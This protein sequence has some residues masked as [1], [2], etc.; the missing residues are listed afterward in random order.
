MRVTSLAFSFF[1]LTSAYIKIQKVTPALKNV[2]GDDI[3][4]P[5][6]R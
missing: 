5:P 1:S 2:I 3:I 4:S 6:L